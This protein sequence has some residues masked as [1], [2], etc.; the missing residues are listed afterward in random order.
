MA[1]G[2]GALLFAPRT[3][4]IA[5]EAGEAESGDFGANRLTARCGSTNEVMP[6]DEKIALSG[7]FEGALVGG[8]VAPLAKFADAATLGN[9]GRLAAAGGADETKEVANLR[10][11]SSNLGP[12]GADIDV[13]KTASTL[14]MD[15]STKSS[16]TL[17]PTR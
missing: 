13:A 5:A 17:V 6:G 10:V 15:L 16:V 2:E 11:G 1:S 14:L 4:P 7:K 12:S 3:V 9:C 8:L